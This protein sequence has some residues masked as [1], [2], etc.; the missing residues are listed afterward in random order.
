MIIFLK[1]LQFKNA[2]RKYTLLCFDKRDNK[3]LMATG[4]TISDEAKSGT[5]TR[6]AVALISQVTATR[7]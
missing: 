1:K 7:E 4:K 6:M 2:R 3:A 5:N